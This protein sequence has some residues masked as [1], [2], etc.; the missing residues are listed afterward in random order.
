MTG[1]KIALLTTKSSD[2][3]TTTAG[4]RQSPGLV[5]ALEL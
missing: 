2:S 5:S 4:D 1:T 3:A